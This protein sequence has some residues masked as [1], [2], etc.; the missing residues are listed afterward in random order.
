MTNWYTTR[1]AVKLA[2]GIQGSQHDSAIDAAIDAASR[3]VDNLSMTRWI[4]ITE[5]RKYDAAYPALRGRRLYLDHDLI[6]IDTFTDQGDE[7]VAVNAT[8]YRLMP[9]NHGPPYSWLEL[10]LDVTTAEFRADPDTHQQSLRITGKWASNDNTI[11]ASEV[12]TNQNNSQTTLL[13]ADGSK[14]DV[15]DTLLIGSEQEFVSGRTDADLG[16]NTHGST[17]AMTVD[18]TDKT[19]TL[20]SAPTDAVTVG[21]VMRI[22]SERMLVEAINSTSSFEVERAYDGTTL[23]AHSTGDDVYIFRTYTVTR[24]VNGTTVAE[25]NDGVAITKYAPPVDI[26]ELTLGTA[27][28][29]FQQQRAGWG[30]EIGRGESAREFRGGEIE[31]LRKR[32]MANNRRHLVESF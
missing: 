32:V 14:I 11:A 17:G 30:R 20:A 28:T 10:L 8:E 13:V 22:G 25:H 29:R 18:K 6:S 12:G 21:E 15:G 23:A 3:E 26:Q 4:P 5:T 27:V 19:L 16:I 7:A 31:R 9:E 24:N 2:A 1:E